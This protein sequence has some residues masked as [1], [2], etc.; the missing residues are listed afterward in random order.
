M[1]GKTPGFLE[2]N[3]ILGFPSDGSL[4]PNG[5]LT[6]VN[7]SEGLPCPIAEKFGECS[8]D[9]WKKLSR[10]HNGRF[11]VALSTKIQKIAGLLMLSLGAFAFLPLPSAAS[12]PTAEG[13]KETILGSGKVWE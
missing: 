4:T 8:L 9:L 2:A 6:S 11:S 12:P 5:L 1:L 7:V 3:S 10:G 13:G